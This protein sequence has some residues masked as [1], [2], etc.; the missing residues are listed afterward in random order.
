MN[1]TN[2]DSLERELHRLI[3]DGLMVTQLWD[4]ITEIYADLKVDDE[5]RSKIWKQHLTVPAYQPIIQSLWS[6]LCI[7]LTRWDE[8]TTREHRSLSVHYLVDCTVARPNPDKALVAAQ[9]RY[10][11]AIAPIKKYRNKSLS[12]ADL[13]YTHGKLN[14]PVLDE[15][16]ISEAVDSFKL[17][18]DLLHRK[19]SKEPDTSIGLSSWNA[20]SNFVSLIHCAERLKRIR[21]VV[22]DHSVAENTKLGTIVE[23]LIKRSI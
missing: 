8:N 23:L 7:T 4:L 14:L 2:D 5:A 20:G 16:V 13:K 17:L 3:S 9:D 18:V 21:D 19:L 22:F 6:N 11:K 10:S 15:P 1:D 12:H